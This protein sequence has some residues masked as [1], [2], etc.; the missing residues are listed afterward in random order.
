[1]SLDDLVAP[2]A[3]YPDQLLG[4]LLIAATNPQEV[5]DLGNWLIENQNLKSDQA[6]DAAKKAGFGTSAQYLAAFPQVV[7]NMC[8]EMDWTTQLGEAFKSNQQGV[9]AAVQQKRAQAKQQGNLNSSPQMTVDTKQDNGKDV[10]QI[11]PTNPEVVYVPQYN[12]TTIYNTPAP[13]PATTPTTTAEASSGVSTGAA[14]GIGLLSFGIGMAVG[15]SLHNDYYPYPSWG[16]G[17]MYYGGRPYYPPP[18][19]PPVYPGYRPAPYYHPPA[20]Y[21]WNQYNHNVNVN[22]NNN[23]YYNRY[24][25]TNTNRPGTANTGYLGANNNR[26]A[27]NNNRAGQTGYLGAH[28]EANRNERPGAGM[29]NANPAIANRGNVGAANRPETRTGVGNA[30]RPNV[31]NAARPDAGNLGASAR[32][33]TAANRPATMPAGGGSGGFSRPSGGGDRGFGGGGAQANRP[34]PQ[35]RSGG[36]AF[37]GGNSNARSERAASSRGHESMG[38][39]GGGRR[40]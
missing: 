29:A 38:A 8:Q 25:N 24:R 19:R 11:A 4:Q 30:S 13:A 37:G 28:P 32:P 10:I 21:R 14:I 26:A 27:I 2:V 35:N 17:G 5:L 15:S 20:N 40:R 39:G 3:L 12:T 7:D 1:M 36:G 31:G 6:P 34:E 23:N 18:Y 9:M 16:Y 33:A 22:V